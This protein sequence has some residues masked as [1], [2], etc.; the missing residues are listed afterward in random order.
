MSSTF[1]STLDEDLMRH[2]EQ[3]SELAGVKKPKPKA[4]GPRTFDYKDGFSPIMSV[5]PLKSAALNIPIRVFKPEDWPEH[6]RKFIPKV[7]DHYVFDSDATLA[8]CA[9]LFSDK[10]R[11]LVGVFFAHGPKGSGKTT[12]TQQICARINMPW[13][14][15][16]CK[17]DMESAA[18]FGSIKYD[19]VHGMTWVDGPAAELARNGGCLCVDEVSRAPSGINASMMAMT[20]K[21]SNI[22][23][24]DKPGSSDEKFIKPHE[25]FRIAF[26]DNTELQGDTTG[27]YVGTNVQDEAFIDRIGTTIR[28]GYLAPAHEVA[29][30]TGK[31]KDIDN[32][33]AQ[34]MVQL[35]KMIRESYDSGNIG[36]TMSPRGLLEWADKIAFWQDEGKAF[37]LAFYNKLTTTDQA[38]VAEFFHTVFAVNL[39]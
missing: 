10:P 25:W 13:I 4:T 7:D 22:Y 20:E 30:I 12:L 34:K 33:T 6:L 37:K 35:A 32:P 17:E 5:I 39:K 3:A 19:P 31:V 9:E 24:A 2:L 21:G 15:V 38:V 18:L 1:S 14:R 28:L 8:C 11:E 29:I 27:K 16:N 23:L 26:T 36:Y